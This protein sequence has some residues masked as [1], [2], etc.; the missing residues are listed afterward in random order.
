MKKLDYDTIYRMAWWLCAVTLPWTIPANSI[1]LII[2]ACVW[3]ADAQWK[4]KWERLRNSPWVFA[5]FAFFLLHVFG[6]LYSSD[7]HGAGFELE[8]KL[9]FILLPLIAATG[10]P[11][12]EAAIDKLRMGFVYSCALLTAGSLLYTLFYFWYSPPALANFDAETD[13]LF[14]QFNPAAANFWQYF[15]YIQV[16]TWMDLHPGYFSMHVIL[17][18]LFLVE[19][20]TR[21][22]QV[23]MGYLGLI[24]L[25]VIV[26]SFLT[27]R[28]AI[29][30]IVVLLC[31]FIFRYREARLQPGVLAGGAL[32]LLFGL[33][34]LNP[35]SRFR[36]IQE[37]SATMLQINS[38]TGQWNS[39][40]LRLL[41]W[42]ASAAAIRTNGLIGVGTGDAQTKLNEYYAGYANQAKTLNYN[43]HNQYLQTT[44]ELGIPGLLLL[45][46]CIFLPFARIQRSTLYTSFIIL[47]SLMCLTE[48]MLARQKGIVF[49]TLFQSLFLS[50]KSET[51]R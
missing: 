36:T 7:V 45:L 50:G 5:F 6:V 15:S 46:N 17:C 3:L 29:V 24:G 35:V 33:I 12:D 41:E 18:I 1:S 39:V 44:I 23:K 11:L 49:F 20:M 51:G 37:P 40:N 16:V 8:K 19:R 21:T 27:S 32:V 43:A 28:M 10:K 48:S 34:W 9:T 38:G 13:A 31:Y 2:L 26:L 30:S 42:R 22:H 47:F 4:A 25:F 14:H